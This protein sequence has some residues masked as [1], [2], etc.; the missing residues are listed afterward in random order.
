MKGSYCIYCHE[1]KINGKKYIGQTKNNPKQR[2]KNGEGYKGSPLFYNAIQK[3]GWDNF[4]H[5]I[6]IG[7]LTLEQ[8]NEQ[9]EYFIDKLKTR[10]KRFGYNIRSGGDNQLW[11]DEARRNLSRARKA[12]VDS[13]PKR[14]NRKM[15]YQYDLD[16][17]Y[18]NCYESADFASKITNIRESSI[19]SCCHHRKN[20]KSAGGYRWEYYKV[21]KLLSAYHKNS[22]G[23]NRI[24]VVQ[25]D[26]NGVVLREWDSIAAIVTELGISQYNILAYCDK[27]KIPPDNMIWDYKEGE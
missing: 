7:G 14:Y 15:V 24:R 27:K 12:A 4:Y 26:S 1:N 5:Y 10:D 17:N 9:E 16:G 3:Y 6:V 22:G 8:A 13:D 21:D 20:H 25:K 18:I 19:R 23:Q 2:W 11:T